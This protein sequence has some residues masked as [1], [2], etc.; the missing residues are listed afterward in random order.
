MAW[1]VFLFL[2]S[3]YTKHRWGLG[4]NV[5]YQDYDIVDSFTALC[6]LRS[7][8]AIR[9]AVPICGTRLSSN[10]TRLMGQSEY[11]YVYIQYEQLGQCKPRCSTRSDMHSTCSLNPARC[12]SPCNPLGRE[13]RH[14]F[15]P[16]YCI[17]LQ[18]RASHRRTHFMIVTMPRLRECEAVFD[19]PTCC[20]DWVP[21][22]ALDRLQY[23][24]EVRRK[25]YGHLCMQFTYSQ[26][27]RLGEAEN[28]IL[29]HGELLGNSEF[30]YLYLH[31]FP[32]SDCRRADGLV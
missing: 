5:S 19:E 22:A 9:A 23:Q 7:A 20:F 27:S 32:T 28:C 12:F 29:F 15:L 16:L 26:Q 4:K 30:L 24:M 11:E 2:C 13:R 8:T 3:T 18:S 1:A 21:V 25:R 31:P 10:E 14:P 6:N 17:V